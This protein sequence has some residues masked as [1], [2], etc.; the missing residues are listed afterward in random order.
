MSDCLP[1]L[2]LPVRRNLP[3]AVNVAMAQQQHW[4]RS[5]HVVAGSGTP[6][7]R[8]RTAALASLLASSLA[9]IPEGAIDDNKSCRRIPSNQM[10]LNFSRTRPVT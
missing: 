1:K 7:V 6:P 3:P 4:A 2:D 10:L 8:A 5:I 9:W